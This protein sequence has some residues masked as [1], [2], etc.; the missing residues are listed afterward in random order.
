MAKSS[1]KEITTAAEGKAGNNSGEK[2]M[3]SIRTI[4]IEKGMMYNLCSLY[5]A[6]HSIISPEINTPNKKIECIVN[7]C[8]FIIS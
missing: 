1:V 6:V 4:S 2:P 3:R 5:F 7:K 8:H